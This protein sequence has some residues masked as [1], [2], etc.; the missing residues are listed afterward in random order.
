MTWSAATL[1]K[2]AEVNSTAVAKILMLFMI[3]SSGVLLGE[4]LLSLDVL[5][6]RPLGGNGKS[7]SFEYLHQIN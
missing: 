4:R 7:E 5:N 6:D 2:E 1:A 3:Q